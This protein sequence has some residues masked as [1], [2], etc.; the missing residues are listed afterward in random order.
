MLAKN[1]KKQKRVN[2]FLLP[3]DVEPISYNI[4]LTPDLQKFT[5][6]GEEGISVKIKNPV[7]RITLHSVG[8]GI[9]YVQLLPDDQEALE[10]KKISFDEKKETV[11][12][13]FG[14]PL[15]KGAATLMIDFT[16]ELNDKLH[17]FYR[18]S[19][20][21]SGVKKFGAATQ[22]EAIDARRAFPCFDEPDR[23][24]NFEIQL[25]A[26]KD[27]TALSNMPAETEMPWTDDKKIVYFGKT[28]KMSTYLTAWVVAD[29][30]YLEAYD[31]NGVRIRVYT[32]PDKKDFGKFALECA[33]HDLPYYADY[34]KIPY[35]WGKLDLVALTDFAAGAMENCGLL[36][37][38]ETALLIDPKNSSAA[39]K[40]R[41]ADVVAHEIGHMWFGDLVTM[42]WWDHIWLNEGFA[43]FAEMRAVA[44]QFPEWKRDLRFVA[45]D[46]VAALHD[47][48]KKN[49]HPI[50]PE[51]E[52]PEKVREIFD[53]TTYSGGSSV[54]LMIEQY[55]G[56]KGFRKGIHN[57]IKKHKYGNITT[58]DLWEELG[59]A[60]H[61]PVAAIM[62]SYTRQA[63][64]PVILVN[65]L[66]HGVGKKAKVVLRLEQ[67]RFLFDGSKARDNM[68]WKVP[69]GF[70]TPRTKDKAHTF[71]YMDKRK[72][73]F[74]VEASE[75]DWIKLNPG[76]TSLYRVAYPKDMWRMLLYAVQM[77]RLSPADRLGLVDDGLALARAGYMKTSQALDMIEAHY[78]END[79]F[80]WTV[81]SSKIGAVANLIS[82]QDYK[83]KFDYFAANFFNPTAN[84]V[85]WKKT[86][87]ESHQ[88]TLLRSLVLRNA[89]A[90]GDEEVI[91]EAKERFDSFFANG[92]LD[93]DIRQMVYAVVAENGDESDY[94]KLLTVYDST[95]LHEE[96]V[97]V[98]RALGSSRNQDV[99]KKILDM[100]FGERIRIQD[101]PILLGNLGS[102]SYAQKAVWQFVKNNWGVFKEKFPGGRFETVLDIIE[103]TVSGFT[104]VEDLGDV[105]AFFKAE[106]LT[107]KGTIKKCLEMIRSNIAW[108]KRDKEDI[109]NW[110]EGN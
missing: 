84:I 75:S 34:Y 46:V 73:S 58:D 107:N 97:R 39:A 36:T 103:A 67:K 28:P 110:L 86:P 69:I 4:C 2:P 22:F 82:G 54:C 8:L 26:P 23:K 106:G 11:T 108:L 64:Y 19:Y 24:A 3:R 31:K 44:H 79:Y 93:P 56:E 100:T 99:I 71:Q 9:T 27:M 62:G 52:D 38:R 66:V 77:E 13:D 18:T 43:T 32:T 45:E 47:M 72:A 50:E 40:E 1:A 51:I 15:K 92:E 96:K 17:G 6:T 59:K 10:P 42:R 94:K 20:E 95:E 33:L 57:N 60:T 70:A 5:F 89:A 104:T 78:H 48:D 98:I 30:N 21:I 91:E 80:V 65:K 83:K 12:F 68:L 37:F 109:R 88:T 14:R 76:Q 7:S 102:N 87:C 25:I 16:G 101:I 74:A 35:P 41:V 53:T 105:K 85:G 49:S 81:V 61:K 63:G 90:Y 55:L 29:L